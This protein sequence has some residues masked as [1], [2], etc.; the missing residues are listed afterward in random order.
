M[1]GGIPRRQRRRGSSSPVFPGLARRFA[2]VGVGCPMRIAPP[3]RPVAT[4]ADRRPRPAGRAGQAYPTRV[5]DGLRRRRGLDA[6]QVPARHHF[7]AVELV[8][9]WEPHSLG[10]VAPA[11]RRPLSPT[12][13]P[14]HG[15]YVAVRAAPKEMVG[16]LP[17]LGSNRPES[18]GSTPS[19]PR[20]RQAEQEGREGARTQPLGA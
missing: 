17:R 3:R 12:H 6:T 13:L 14:A 9:F 19:P 2:R 16:G 20:S 10:S 4:K 5:V 1:R 11:L 7:G 15:V 8:A 18:R